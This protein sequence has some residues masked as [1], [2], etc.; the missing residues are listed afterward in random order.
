MRILDEFSRL[1]LSGESLTVTISAGGTLLHPGDT[2]ES[3]VHRADNLMYQCK[4]YGRNRVKV[5]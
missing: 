3:N 4:Q 2:P 5:G 1:D